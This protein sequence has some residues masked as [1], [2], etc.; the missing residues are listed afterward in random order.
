M[1]KIWVNIIKKVEDTIV[2]LTQKELNF[3]NFFN[4]SYKLEVRKSVL[5]R[6]GK[7]N[8]TD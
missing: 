8:L 2:F 1:S 3:D 4:V 5:Q 7:G 6:N